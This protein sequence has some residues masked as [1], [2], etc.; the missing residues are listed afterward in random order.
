MTVEVK[1]LQPGQP[2]TDDGK[3][4]SLELIEIIQRLVERVE[5][6]ETRLAA[7]EP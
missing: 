4:G 5:D 6:L 7:L 1:E 3:N 2:V